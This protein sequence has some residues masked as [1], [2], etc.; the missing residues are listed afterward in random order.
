MKNAQFHDKI[1]TIPGE[2][3]ERLKAAV[4]KTVFQFLE[5]GFESPPLRQPFWFLTYE[6]CCR[7]NA[8]PPRQVDADY[9][10]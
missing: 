3:A 8:W 9:R 6:I 2:V 1:T 7:Y 10:M 5:R 4:S